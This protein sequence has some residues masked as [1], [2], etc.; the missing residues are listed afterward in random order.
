MHT[1]DWNASPVEVSDRRDAG[2]P[3]ERRQAVTFTSQRY[4]PLVSRQSIDGDEGL[5]PG[6]KLHVYQQQ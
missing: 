5:I 2:G 4:R 1:A 6:C 3:L